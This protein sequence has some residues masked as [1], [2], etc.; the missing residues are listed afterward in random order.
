LVCNGAVRQDTSWTLVGIAS[1]SL[2]NCPVTVYARVTSA[3]SWI[4]QTIL[5]MH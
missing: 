1:W 4:Q 2:T 3:V 5:T